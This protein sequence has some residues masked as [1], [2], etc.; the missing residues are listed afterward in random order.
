MNRP[1]PSN[2]PGNY[3]PGPG[4]PPGMNRPGPGRPGPGM[5][6]PMGHGPARPPHFGHRPRHGHPRDVFFHFGWPG[7]YYGWGRSHHLRFGDYLLLVLLL[8]T[9][10]NANN[11]LTM[12]ELYYQHASGVSY[13][14]ICGRYNLY[15]PD[16]YNRARFNYN[17]M[18]TY[19]LDQD[20]TFLDWSDSLIR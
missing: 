5:R 7:R 9:I 11:H 14:V 18:Y 15:W 10:N 1:G 17:N 8:Q 19:A 4:R 6:P 20:L 13:E 2:R 12:D 3:G 16:I